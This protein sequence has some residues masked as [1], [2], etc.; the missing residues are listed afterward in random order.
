VR[1]LAGLNAKLGRHPAGSAAN[2]DEAER[3]C[4]RTHSDVLRRMLAVEADATEAVP[5]CVTPA[6][7]FPQHVVIASHL[8]LNENQRSD[9]AR[10]L[11]LP[12]VRLD[13]NL[14]QR[15]LRLQA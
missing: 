10:L 4:R 11:A 6:E 14:A 5:A 2:S 12:R 13:L 1:R 15:C 3:L 7:Q 8:W 9:R